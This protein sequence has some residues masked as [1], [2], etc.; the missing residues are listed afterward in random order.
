M[1]I[2]SSFTVLLDAVMLDAVLLDA[3]LSGTDEA[4]DGIRRFFDLRVGNITALAGRFCDTVREVVG[5]EGDRDRFE[6]L[7]RG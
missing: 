6:C 4:G 1:D 5:E 3:V 7:G 2:I